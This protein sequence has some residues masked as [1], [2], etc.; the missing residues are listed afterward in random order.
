MVVKL[1]ELSLPAC[2]PEHCGDVER[3]AGQ[4]AGVV[5]FRRPDDLLNPAAADAAEDQHF[6]RITA[7]RVDDP[8]FA[9][10]EPEVLL[11]LLAV[12]SVGGAG[13]NDLDDQVRDP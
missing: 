10:A 9:D 4:E 12:V 7:V 13:R 1:T 11:A 3:Q 5:D 8:V 6:A 2:G